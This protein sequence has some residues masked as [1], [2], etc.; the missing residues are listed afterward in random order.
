MSTFID[1]DI[2]GRSKY[3]L[4]P[5][6]SLANLRDVVPTT[7]PDLFRKGPL[8]RNYSVPDLSTG[9]GVE[10]RPRV[11]KPQW[12][13]RYTASHPHR[14]F[15]GGNLTEHYGNNHYNPYFRPPDYSLLPPVRQYYFAHDFPI[16]HPRD[17][18]IAQRNF[19]NYLSLPPTFYRASISTNF[20]KYYPYK[21]RSSDRFLARYWMDN[22]VR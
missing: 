6:R 18:K 9:A 15:R 17:Y 16:D 13:G 20:R 22:Y 5:S 11:F 8:E 2:Y 12:S 1:P 14:H 3:S 19:F 7:P 21:I 4:A 10:H